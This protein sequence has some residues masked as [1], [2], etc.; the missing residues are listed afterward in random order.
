MLQA[1]ME[2]FTS[3]PPVNND[4]EITV[5]YPNGGETFK[6]GEVIAVAGNVYGP[7]TTVKLFYSDNGGSTFDYPLTGCATDNVVAG[8][9]SCNCFSDA[10]YRPHSF[11]GSGAFCWFNSSLSFFFINHNIFKYCC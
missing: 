3:V 8:S 2:D 4:P 10:D 1:A 6:V 7:I 5:T 11:Y 9:F